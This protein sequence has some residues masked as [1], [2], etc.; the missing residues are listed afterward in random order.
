MSIDSGM[1]FNHLIL[2]RPLL[3]LPPI[4]PSIRVFPNE[5]ALHIM[6]PNYWSFSFSISPSSEYSGLISFRIDWFD[7]LGVQGTFKSLLQHHSQVIISPCYCN[8][9][10]KVLEP[11]HGAWSLPRCVSGQQ[12]KERRLGVDR[13]LG[14]LR[15]VP[16]P[17]GSCP[18][19]PFWNFPEPSRGEHMP[20]ETEGLCAA[21]LITTDPGCWERVGR[22]FS[23]CSH[24]PHSHLSEGSCLSEASRRAEHSRAILSILSLLPER[25]R[26]IHLKQDLFLKQ[27]DSHFGPK[28][29][30]EFL[31][32]T[33]GQV[34]LGISCFPKGH[35]VA[36][37][38]LPRAQ[39]SCKHKCCASAPNLW[40]N[41]LQ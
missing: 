7:L 36:S 22:G 21:E 28:F 9:V 6:W 38:G 30:E 2:C 39:A 15:A 32:G 25:D 35:W 14:L 27:N 19:R 23:T 24:H 41:C 12:A 37:A 20:Q 34:G 29:S 1:P 17:E 26:M 13:K 3:L 5:S 10:Y 4:F 11:G 8:E 16:W 31:A 33:G 18:H 40:K